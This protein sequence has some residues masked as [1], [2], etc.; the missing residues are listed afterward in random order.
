M[1]EQATSAAPPRSFAIN[2]LV[3]LAATTVV[4][5][6]MRSMRDIVGTVFLA[7]VLTITVHP[8]R[9]WLESRRLPEWAAS[10]LTLLGTY[11]ILVGLA[12]ALVVS[13][14]QMASLVQEYTPKI[15][16]H[17]ADL[18]SQLHSLGVDQKQIDTLTKAVDPGK[19]VSFIS[20]I[21]G[22]LAGVLGSLFFLLLVLLFTT[23]DTNSTR[24]GLAT[25]MA[26]AP[27]PWPP[28]VSSPGARGTTWASLRS[29][30]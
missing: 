22:D 1:T 16:E 24:R 25:L 20:G 28:S 27:R 26:R 21:L 29:S 17:V 11:L 9:T 5:A 10:I 14:A 7:L 6:G 2:L 3:V 8:I 15:Q 19:L 30:A 23:F 12:L 13:V 18:G 4:L